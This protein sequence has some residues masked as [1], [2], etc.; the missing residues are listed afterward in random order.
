MRNAVENLILRMTGGDRAV[1]EICASAVAGVEDGDVCRRV[2]EAEKT[3]LAAEPSVAQFVDT[4]SSG[5]CAETPFVVC[6]DLLY[7]RRNWR[8]ERNV[9]MRIAAM[10]A[11]VKDESAEPL[12][13]DLCGDLRDEQRSA[14]MTLCRA[15]FAILTGGPG[16]GKT[17]TIAR[18]VRHMQRSMPDLRLALAA[19]T[20][21]AAARMTESMAN[22]GV[23]SA[24]AGTIHALLGSRHDLAGFV[25][26]REN[27]LPVD[28]LIVDEAS[29]IDLPLMS[30]LLDALPAECRLTLV[31]DVDQL[32][33]VERGR[34]FGD[35]CRMPGVPLSRL[36]E[37]ARFSPDGDIA[38]I[39]AAVNGNRPDEVMSI[40][41]G[42]GGAVDYVELGAS[43]PSDAWPEFLETC[44]RG[45][46]GLAASRN[47]ETALAKLN[48]FRV[49]CALRTGPFGVERI[50]G[51]IME[52]LGVDCPVP[53]M[54]T[55]NDRL[56]G[57]SNG[58]V[59]VVMPD[60]PRVLHLPSEGGPRAVRLELLPDVETAFATTIHK[61]QGSEFGD[62][63]I[64][65]PADGENPLLT[66]ELLYTGVTRTKG[67]VHV[68][69]GEAAVRACCMK[70]VER[71]SGLAFPPPGMRRNGSRAMK[72][73]MV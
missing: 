66:R 19:P 60:D 25:H 63:A 18:A 1:A 73:D 55:R 20:G 48:D 68:Y 47:A 10:A 50:N 33:S 27:P 57:V 28:W 51:R 22:A 23:V 70:S 24:P 32:A 11:N 3:M 62:V 38:R 17:H 40:L 36:S 39:A 69:A 43:R 2:D 49:L 30:K 58:D 59:G 4:L 26:G 46:S 5:D 72:P 65:L 7:T 53:V 37:S 61:S 16:T 34:V 45:F 35:L 54:I 31:G 42:N 56:Q 71:L 67:S 14:V 29:M 13:E 12:G 9:A 21:K 6:G 44:R 52:E 41:R 15:Q 64:V 8:Y